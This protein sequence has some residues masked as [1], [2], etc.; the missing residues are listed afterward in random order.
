MKK[1]VF[2][3]I[4][5]PPEAKKEILE[6]I[7]SLKTTSPSIRWIGERNLHLTLK[8]LGYL[9]QDQ[10]EEICPKLTSIV[11]NFKP[12][13]LKL[14]NI[15]FF[16]QKAKIRI[17]GLRLKSS[18]LLTKMGDDISGYLNQLNFIKKEKR[19]F[20]PHITLARVKDG[21]GDSLIKKL[22]KINFYSEWEVKSLEIMESHLS[23]SGAQY[24]ILKSFGLKI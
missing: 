21:I 17:I 18:Q 7:Q 9:D 4:N 6:K 12:F 14:K 13:N 15:L 1:R 3:A 23:G 16:P 22:E 19:Q 2:V 20:T 5:L 24:Q 11:Q 10:L 8:F